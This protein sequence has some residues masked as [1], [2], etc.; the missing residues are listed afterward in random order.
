MYKLSKAPKYYQNQT[1]RKSLKCNV[2][3]ISAHH[4]VPAQEQVI[5]CVV[6]SFEDGLLFVASLE[7]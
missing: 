6:F 4:M 2:K 5:V 1:N 7:S 3:H